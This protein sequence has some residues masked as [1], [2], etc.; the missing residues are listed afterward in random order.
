MAWT[1]PL[2]TGW[3]IVQ[4]FRIKKYFHAC[5]IH[6]REYVCMRERERERVGECL[7]MI[8]IAEVC[9]SRVGGWKSACCV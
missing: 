5:T 3:H 4:K 9:S 2:M 1:L 7:H 6:T 8:L